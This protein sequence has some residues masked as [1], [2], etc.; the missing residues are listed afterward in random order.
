[1]KIKNKKTG[2]IFEISDKEGEKLLVENEE[3]FEPLDKKYVVKTKKPK[4][5]REKVV[6]SSRVYG[7]LNALKKEQIIQ[8][9]NELD[10]KY[11]PKMKKKELIEILKK[12]GGC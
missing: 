10:V 6:V 7:C 12:A 1:M 9:L 3:E 2:Y 11:N 8:E 5:V 4:T